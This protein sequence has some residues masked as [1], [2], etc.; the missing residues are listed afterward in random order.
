LEI[1]NVMTDLTSIVEIIHDMIGQNYHLLNPQEFAKEYILRR[2]KD[3]KRVGVPTI[4]SAPLNSPYS[5]SL[6][7][8]SG[9]GIKPQQ[10]KSS[11]EGFQQVKTKA[12]KKAEASARNT[13]APVGVG[14]RTVPGLVPK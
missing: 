2:H 13:G 1:I 10:T 8:G 12:K 6:R 5:L 9:S 14:G 7:R 11:N 4:P 3:A